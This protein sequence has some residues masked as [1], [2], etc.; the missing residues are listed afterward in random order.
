MRL[1]QHDFFTTAAFYNTNVMV[2][3]CQIRN[4]ECKDKDIDLSAYNE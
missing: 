4:I 3:D 2:P 1:R